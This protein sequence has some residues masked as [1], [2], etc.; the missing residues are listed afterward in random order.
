MNKNKGVSF[1]DSFEISDPREGKALRL[2][3]DKFKKNKVWFKDIDLTQVLLST[4]VSD[5]IKK[6]YLSIY[7]I[8]N[9]KKI[10]FEFSSI[11]KYCFFFK[12]SIVIEK[13]GK[14]NFWFISAAFN[15]LRPNYKDEVNK[16]Y[17]S[18]NAPFFV[19]AKEKRVK[20]NFF[21]I[22]RKIK[23][24]KKIYNSLDSSLPK[25][26]K[27][28]FSKIC[29]KAIDLVE[30]FDNFNQKPQVIFSLKDFQKYENALVQHVKSKGIKT[31]TSQHCVFPEF[32]GG[33]YRYGQ[34]YENCPSEYL[35]SWGEFNENLYKKYSPSIKILRSQ[36]I[37]RPKIIKNESKEKVLIVA[38]SGRRHE[39]ESLKL[40][41]LV[42]ELD[43]KLSFD[44]IIFRLHP[45][46][47]KGKYINLFKNLRF[48]NFIEIE[49]TENFSF[50]YPFKNSIA[51]T[52]LSG[53]YYDLTYL[54]YKT[55]F[56]NYGFKLEKTLPR[57]F[58]PVQTLK[59][60]S[61]QINKLK[62][63][64]SKEWTDL[65][66]KVLK[67]TLNQKVM[68]ERKMIITEEIWKYFNENY[69]K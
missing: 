3:I 11:L 33:N 35:L 38:F 68:E 65:A 40:T 25:T 24:I 30:D 18:K 2:E 37:L 58:P 22:I 63:I 52:S 42:F 8:Y 34:A 20:K 13:K 53:I 54:G 27:L 4:F 9:F 39:A 36:S 14:I 48:R 45:T 15:S 64:N 62:K 5:Y 61:L 49:T 44:K 7:S 41:K 55:I 57:V 17:H 46:I 23:H 67:K 28:K 50:N 6:K 59:E 69:A 19:V 66:N 12:N 26:Q 29:I 47:R 16:F 43:K 32:S 10:L 31:F 56:F 51:I 60:I 21:L 1:F